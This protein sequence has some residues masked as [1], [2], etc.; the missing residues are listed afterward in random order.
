MFHL[1]YYTVFFSVLV[2][3]YPKCPSCLTE[4]GTLGPSRGYVSLMNLVKDL[5]FGNHIRLN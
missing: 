5:L 3:P 2:P 4:V 1:S